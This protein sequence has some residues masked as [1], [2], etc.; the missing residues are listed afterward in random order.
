[1]ER[2]GGGK[3]SGEASMRVM[4]KI[5]E[6]KVAKTGEEKA[7][8]VSKA[9]EGLKKIGGAATWVSIDER[10]S[11]AMDSVCVLNISIKSTRLNALA[12]AGVQAGK[13]LIGTP[14]CKVEV[15]KPIG[16]QV[17]KNLIWEKDTMVM[18]MPPRFLAKLSDLRGFEDG[19]YFLAVYGVVGSV[20]MY[21][22]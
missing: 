3:I 6:T 4:E 13:E 14:A 22:K 18:P 5:S 15:S 19:K 16:G 10:P 8:L 20:E 2:P 9:P 11:N 12:L 17:S 7:R 21:G 1:M